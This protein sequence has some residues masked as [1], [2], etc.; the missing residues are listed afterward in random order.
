MRFLVAILALLAGNGFLLTQRAAGQGGQGW[1]CV[2]APG[3]QGTCLET[4][5]YTCYGC[6]CGGSCINECPE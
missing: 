5:P 3:S 4:C 2:Y 6:N 1:Q